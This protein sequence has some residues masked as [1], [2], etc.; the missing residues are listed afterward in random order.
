MIPSPCKKLCHLN[1]KGYCITCKRSEKEII[2]WKYMSDEEKEQV[3]IN[4][5]VR[6]SNGYTHLD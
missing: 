2:H 3:L 5:E 4:C 6:K 1:E